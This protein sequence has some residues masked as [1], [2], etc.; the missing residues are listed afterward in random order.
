MK[1]KSCVSTSIK[2]SLTHTH[3]HTHAQCVVAVCS[4]S[5]YRSAAHAARV[6]LLVKFLRR[7]FLF[8]KRFSIS[9]SQ[10]LFFLVL[11]SVVFLCVCC[12]THIH[13]LSCCLCY[14]FVAFFV[15]NLCAAVR[16]VSVSFVIS[17]ARARLFLAT[18]HCC[19][20]CLSS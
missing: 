11:L 1:I 5:L 20:C 10:L 13:I 6:A 8:R 15:S 12:H 14:I 17:A 19:C 2:A 9:A 7:I 18:T 16:F 4:V 3:T